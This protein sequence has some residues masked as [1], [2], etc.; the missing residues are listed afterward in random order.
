MSQLVIFMKSYPHP[1]EHCPHSSNNTKFD[2]V[3]RDAIMILG[4]SD[5]QR[6]VDSNN[7]GSMVPSR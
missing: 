4:L 3:G 1:R 6:D 7:L 5:L 2:D